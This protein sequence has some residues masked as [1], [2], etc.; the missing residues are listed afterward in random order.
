[1]EKKAPDRSGTFGSFEGLHPPFIDLTLMS[2][3]GAALFIA[4]IRTGGQG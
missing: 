1:M 3:R 2:R 4:Y